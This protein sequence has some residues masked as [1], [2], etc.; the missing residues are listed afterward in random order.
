[1][2]PLGGPVVPLEKGRTARVLRASTS[3]RRW[4]EEAELEV[5]SAKGV[6][7]EVGSSERVTIGNGESGE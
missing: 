5:N 1:M 4:K 3:G 2:T 6:A 7:E